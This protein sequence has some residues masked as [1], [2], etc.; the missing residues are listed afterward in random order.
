M[1]DELNQ[2]KYRE[3]EAELRR[4]AARP[5][6]PQQRIKRIVRDLKWRL[7]PST[8]PNPWD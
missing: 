3:A 2:E 1:L 6:N 5:R 7:R 8:R 4:R